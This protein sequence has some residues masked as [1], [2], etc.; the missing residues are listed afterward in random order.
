M[1]G[2]YFDTN[3][4]NSVNTAFSGVGGVRT[5]H[6]NLTVRGCTVWQ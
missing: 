5:T 6:S 3:E 1:T 4:E 2:T